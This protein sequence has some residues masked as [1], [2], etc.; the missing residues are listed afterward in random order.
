MGRLLRYIVCGVVLMAAA[1]CRNGK[2]DEEEV[3]SAIKALDTILE[4]EEIIEY[5]KHS[6]IESLKAGIRE[7]MSNDE[8]YWAL[9]EIFNEYFQYDVDSAMFYAHR[10]IKLATAMGDREK[11]YDAVLDIADR[12]AISGMNEEAL[13]QI[14]QIDTCGLDHELA[15]RRHSLL[16]TVYSNLIS[17]SSDPVLTRRY[18]MQRSK[19]RDMMMQALDSTDIATAYLDANILMEQDKVEQARALL[20]EWASRDDID[21]KEKGI[22]CYSIAMTYRMEGDRTKAKTWLARSA[23]YDLQVPKYEYMSLIELAGMLYE[24]GDIERAYTYI[25]R[26]VNDAVRA[27]A[28]SSKETV[29]VLM[30]IIANSYDTMMKDKNVQMKYFLAIMGFMLVLLVFLTLVLMKEKQRVADAELLTRERNEQL[31]RLNEELKKSNM[32]LR[33][34]NGI[35]DSYLGRYLNMC[36]DYI[37]GLDRYRSSIRKIAKEEG[38]AELLNALKSKAFMEEELE[39]FYAQFDA[40]FLDLFPDF[41]PQLNELLQE[42]K[43]IE[44]HSKNKILS[45]E[46]RVLALIRLG[47][48]DS[49]RIAHFLRRSV[50]TIYNYRVKMK[51]SASIDR[52]EF[53]KE[54]MKIGRRL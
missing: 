51:N 6:R 22:L 43:Q 2:D 44:V 47:V 12:Y 32:L 54:L 8:L 52:E 45:T 18:E 5:G 3:A 35:K 19:Y 53:E 1:A 17:S 21:L 49:V 33:E 34:S 37:D 23:T 48:N 24:D 36:S 42:D 16:N 29:F 39:G 26:S 20:L 38:T 28:Q 40:T 11:I 30:P 50:S 7:N 46:L 41:I 13:R 9:N 14:A 25:T 4:N 31:G 15:K 10:K 27:K